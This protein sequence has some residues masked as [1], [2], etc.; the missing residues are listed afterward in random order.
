MGHYVSGTKNGSQL[1][2]Y[3]SSTPLMRVKRVVNVQEIAIAMRKAREEGK[4]CLSHQ[5][6]GEKQEVFN[7]EAFASVMAEAKRAGLIWVEEP[8]APTE[9]EKPQTWPLE[10]VECVICTQVFS[11][12][13]NQVVKTCSVDCGAVYR[14]QIHTAKQLRMRGV[15]EPKK[16]HCGKLVSSLNALTCSKVCAETVRL[17]SWHTTRAAK[18]GGR[19]AR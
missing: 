15:K 11:R 19:D 13:K 17:E 2:G 9:P 10:Q 18:K 14:S 1:I 7:P 3:R 16:C 6:L 4:M 5:T 8:M 12:R